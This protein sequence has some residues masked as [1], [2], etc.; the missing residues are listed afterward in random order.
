M[1]ERQI[2][3]QIEGL[4][5]AVVSP[6]SK[7]ASKIFTDSQDD[8]NH[9]RSPETDSAEKNDDFVIERNGVEERIDGDPEAHEQ[10]GPHNSD[11]SND[12]PAAK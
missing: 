1:L 5:K 10:H 7:L 2:S 8:R 4:C 12:G 11:P 6:I 3:S 9:N